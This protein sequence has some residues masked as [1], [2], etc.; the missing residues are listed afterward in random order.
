M[1]QYAMDLLYK[2]LTEQKRTN[3]LLAQLVE[4]STPAELTAVTVLDALTDAFDVT[5]EKPKTKRSAKK[6]DE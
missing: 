5:E 6:V 2:L 1:N 4:Q 3:E